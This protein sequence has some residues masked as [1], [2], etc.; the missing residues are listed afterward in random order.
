[1]ARFVNTREREE[2]ETKLYLNRM[3]KTI[4]TRVQDTVFPHWR[5][6]KSLQGWSCMSFPSVLKNRKELGNVYTLKQPVYSG[7]FSNLRLPA[8]ARPLTQRRPLSQEQEVKAKKV[9]TEGG[10]AEA[11]LSKMGRKHGAQLMADYR[12]AVE[13]NQKMK[14]FNKLSSGT[15]TTCT[16]EER[17]ETAAKLN[18]RS[19]DWFAL[20]PNT[21]VLGPNVDPL[22]SR[23]VK[24]LDEIHL[25]NEESDE[26]EETFAYKVKALVMNRGCQEA[27]SRS[28]P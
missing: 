13:E 20:R 1:M 27:T 22:R 14:A 7:E 23:K 3:T 25:D 2:K 6:H 11:F 28:L 4:N 26:D 24:Q 12:D 21:A 18:K 19:E 10:Y 5:S 8:T 9:A 16:Y 17:K 15:L